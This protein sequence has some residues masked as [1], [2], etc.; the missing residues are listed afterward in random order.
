MN[1]AFFPDWLL[2]MKTTLPEPRYW[3]YD[4]GDGWQVF[5]GKSAEDND[6]VSF[7]LALPT[8]LWFHLNGAPGSHVLL[9]GPEGVKPPKAMVEAA[10]GIAAYHSKARNGGR[11]SVDCCLAADVSKP[12]RAPAGM[13]NIR[14]AK[15]IRAMPRLPG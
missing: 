10:A 9:R 7:R 13:V 3:T 1:G 4:L 14:H 2:H 12:P 6:L 8:D 5:A 11:C 15:S